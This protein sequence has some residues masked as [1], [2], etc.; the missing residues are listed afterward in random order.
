MTEAIQLQLIITFG[1]LGGTGI[2]TLGSI[3]IAIANRT[4]QHAKAASD[5]TAETRDQVKNDHTVNLRDD[6]DGKQADVLA[7]LKTIIDTQGRQGRQI[8]LLFRQDREMAEEL[9]HTQQP[10]PRSN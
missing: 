3:L 7:T 5:N 2:I 9:E 1:A 8:A 10:R 6:L 4:R